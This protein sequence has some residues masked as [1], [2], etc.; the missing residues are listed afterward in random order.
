MK[1]I[2]RSRLPRFFVVLFCVLL[3][4]VGIFWRH[5]LG[6][7]VWYVAAP[8]ALHNPLAGVLRSFHT[9]AQ[10]AQENEAL[11]AELA[12]TTAQLA[13]RGVLYQENIQLKA[14]LGR[15]GN[16]HTLLAGVL[17]RPPATPYD[18]LMIDA[19]R[20]EGVRAGALVYAG[21]SV[22]IGTVDAVY[23]GTSR[24]VLFSAPGETYQGMLME[25]TAHPA[26]P[27]V[28][29]GEGGATMTAEVPVG[30]IVAAGDAILLPGVAGGYLARVVAV[31]TKK[32]ESFNTL[33]M[34]LP[35][36]PQELRMVEVEK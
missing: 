9:N 11:R 21:G 6:G 36:N 4:G 24:V 19:G 35:V 3:L 29:Q 33:Y 26:L 1:R 23:D 25:S 22:V 20:T 30:S 13:D 17:M 18:T 28:V 12:S 7:F 8:L 5:T 10:L 27:V 31:E 34:Q 14:R 32:G 16:V 2:S 15:D